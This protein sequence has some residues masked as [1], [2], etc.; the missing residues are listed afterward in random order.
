MKGEPG[1]LYTVDER[2][3]LAKE[4]LPESLTVLGELAWCLHCECVFPVG[5]LRLVWDDG[6]DVW[7]LLCADK[8]C[9]GSYPGD[10]WAYHETR[11]E[12]ASHWP[13]RPQRGQHIP[14]NS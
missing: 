10:L 11:R 2:P 4:H 14:L 13:K 3:D 6:F 8:T 7:A 1:G 5:A 12:Q 9:D